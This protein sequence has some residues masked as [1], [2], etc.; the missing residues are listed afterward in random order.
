M[1]NIQVIRYMSKSFATNSSSSSSSSAFGVVVDPSPGVVEFPSV[2]E[3][4]GV[5]D[6]IAVVDPPGVVELPSGVVDPLVPPLT[7]RTTRS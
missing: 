6:S 1:S 2:V 4:A 3:P 5:V 7:N